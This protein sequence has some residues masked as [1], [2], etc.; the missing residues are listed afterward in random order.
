ME[1]IKVGGK[2]KRQVSLRQEVL[3]GFHLKYV[4]MTQRHPT[5]DLEN[6]GIAVRIS[7]ISCIEAE[8]CDILYLL[9]V[10]VSLL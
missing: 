7:L 1:E 4:S 9:P 2:R 3:Y 10:N 6:M 8:I 5:V